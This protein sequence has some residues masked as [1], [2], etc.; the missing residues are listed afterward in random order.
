MATVDGWTLGNPEAV[1]AVATVFAF[2]AA[3]FAVGIEMRNSRRLAQE[4]ADRA[5]AAERD[6]ASMI[7]VW[8]ERLS[9]NAHTQY[10]G[11]KYANDSPHPITAVVI[12]DTEGR[13]PEGTVVVKDAVYQATVLKPDERATVSLPN[14]SWLHEGGDPGRYVLAFTDR[15]GIRWHRHGDGRLVKV[16]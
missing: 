14:W 15:N 16:T 11:L 6:Q 12:T 10:T 8:P 1:E 3:G 9:I 7:S 13:P 4:I 5:A 2:V